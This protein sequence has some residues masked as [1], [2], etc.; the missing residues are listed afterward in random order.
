[1]QATVT[2][3]GALG[4]AKKPKAPKKPKARKLPKGQT[5][6]TA[7]I[8]D[9]TPSIFQT[10]LI[11]APPPAPSY[12]APS[13]IAPSAPQG[14]STRDGIFNLAQQGLSVFANKQSGGNFVQQEAQLTQGE[15]DP[16]TAKSAAQGVGK[17]LDEL[18]K[19]VSSKPLLFG[20]IGV[21]LLLLFMKPPSRRR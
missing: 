4:K 6:V 1:M 8:I 15:N 20:G 18:G 3:L 13:Y 21:A 2:N 17:S 12:I 11:G 5:R 19:T 10:D 9:F 7:P 14:H 16:N